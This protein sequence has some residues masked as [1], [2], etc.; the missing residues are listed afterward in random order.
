MQSNKKTKTKGKVKNNSFSSCK[1]KETQ[2]ESSS[3]IR[4]ALSKFLTNLCE[5]KY[6]EANKDLEKAVETKVKNKIKKSAKSVA[7]KNKLKKGSK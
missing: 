5:K 7:D 1:K 2:E 4:K 6:A 3:Y